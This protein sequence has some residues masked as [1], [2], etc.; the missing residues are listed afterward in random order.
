M[1]QR[2][3][4]WLKADEAHGVYQLSREGKVLKESMNPYI[5]EVYLDAWETA[6]Y[7]IEHEGTDT[8]D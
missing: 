8:L 5:I 3:H 7:V 6:T 2:S 4:L 1:A